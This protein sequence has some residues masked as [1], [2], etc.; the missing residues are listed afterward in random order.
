MRAATKGSAQQ[1]RP[2][3]GPFGRVL[4][5]ALALAMIGVGCE[6]TDPT[7][8]PTTI[9]I[10]SEH[11]FDVDRLFYA[12]GLAQATGT[13]SGIVVE[14]HGV[15]VAEGHYMDVPPWGLNETW[16]VTAAMT[17]LLTGVALD[18]GYLEGLDQPLG[19]LLVPWSD[20]LDQDKAGITIRQLL[21]MTSG[22]SRPA[23]SPE[24]FFTWMD[25]M[26]QVA[27]VLDLPLLAPP[28]ER[29]RFDDGAAHLLA[30]AL[31]EASGMNLWEL[32][33]EALLEPMGIPQVEWAVDP[34]GVNYGAF[35]LRMRTRDMVKLGRLVLDEGRWDGHQLVSEDW[36]RAMI[37]PRVHPYPDSPEWG[38]GYLWKVGRCRGHT[39]FY[40]N[41]YGGQILVALPDLE[42]VVAVTSAYTD[43][44]AAANESYEAAWGI[45]LDQILPS[46]H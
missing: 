2:V 20:H 31:R 23:G 27:W 9:T 26:D 37:T 11:G 24:E 7:I 33:S 18:R 19:E 28:G 21:T 45:I 3:A 15:V 14:R 42:L 25:Q 17:S 4:L 39:C 12:M 46:V 5:S 43:D 41:G 36:V 29:Y 1:S 30:A 16:S 6:D 34:Q 35:G 32:A 13:V 38:Y 40:Q 44:A 8:P 22:V 10:A